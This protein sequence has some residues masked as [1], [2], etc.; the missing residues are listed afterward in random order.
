MHQ[1]ELCYNNESEQMLCT[2][3]RPL[4][5][6]KLFVLE[7]LHKQLFKCSIDVY[8][9]DYCGVGRQTIA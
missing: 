9:D 5:L 8:G 7:K 6:N 1:Y 3:N 2:S 4:S